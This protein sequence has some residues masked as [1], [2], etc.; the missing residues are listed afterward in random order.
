MQKT[1]IT[2]AP[3]G[4]LCTRTEE[5]NHV[6]TIW[7]RARCRTGVHKEIPVRLSFTEKFTWVRNCE[8]TAKPLNSNPNFTLKWG[9][10]E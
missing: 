5:E 1:G 3:P 4:G 2:T 9:G 6:K 7:F 8:T 10:N